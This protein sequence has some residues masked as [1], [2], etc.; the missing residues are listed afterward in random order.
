M[1]FSKWFLPKPYNLGYLPEENGHKVCFA[2]YGN[3]KGKPV[4]LFHGG[5][6]GSCKARHLK[7]I[8]LKK[9]RVITLDQRGCGL[10]LPLGQIENNTTQDILK[11]YDRLINLL[12][13]E[14]KVILRGGSWG[15]TL[16]LLWAEKNPQKV[17]KML[18]SQV[19]L[20]NNDFHNW[21][22]NGTKYIYP[23]FVE[24]MSKKSK[25]NITTYYNKLIQS[26]NKNKQ[27][28]AIN[29]FGWYER[30]CGSM[31]PKFACFSDVCNTEL[32]SNRIYMHYA[33]N[34]FFLTENDILRNTSKIKGINTVIVHNRLDLICPFKGAYDL[35][36]KM[37]NSELI[38][39]EEF[40]HV[41]NKIHKT[42]INKLNKALK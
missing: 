8:N 34:N 26:I 32:A 30:I 2:E 24:Y 42:I 3:K 10:S 22:F 13:I 28:E 19:F 9:Y 16:A 7:G 21:E 11:D 29:E 1:F 5:P 25:G 36:I 27:L 38:V 41:G 33:A 35:H 17:E 31:A 18:L 15:S 37:N 40:G 14:E 6:G 12:N 20:A 39:V 23:E 4:L